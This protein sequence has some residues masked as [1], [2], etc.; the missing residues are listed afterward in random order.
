[1]SI[2]LHDLRFNN[3]IISGTDMIENVICSSM[4]CS[5]MIIIIIFEMLFLI[6]QLIRMSEFVKFLS[7]VHYLS[8]KLC[9]QHLQPKL[10]NQRG[11]KCTSV[12]CSS[13]VLI[14]ISFSMYQDSYR[15]LNLSTTISKKYPPYLIAEFLLLVNKLNIIIIKQKRYSNSVVICEGGLHMFFS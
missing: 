7:T 4:K 14:W 5:Y 8:V 10:I 12:L 13:S 11:K 3:W 9:A 2:F 1:M 6:L 15:T